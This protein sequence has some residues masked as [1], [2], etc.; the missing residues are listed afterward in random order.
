MGL[1]LVF[2]GR[3]SCCR[4]CT[5]DQK[6]EQESEYEVVIVTGHG[7]SLRRSYRQSTSPPVYTPMVTFAK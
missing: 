1:G 2:T 4:D 5:R 6:E 7:D 3:Y